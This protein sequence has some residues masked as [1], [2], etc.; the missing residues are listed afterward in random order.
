MLWK[1]KSNCQLDRLIDRDIKKTKEKLK[2]VK[3]KDT[4]SFESI[5]ALSFVRH[6]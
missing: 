5:F 4:G 6:M 1:A 3:E 2:Q